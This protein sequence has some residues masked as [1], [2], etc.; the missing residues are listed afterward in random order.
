[1]VAVVT[2]GDAPRRPA[3]RELV[4][5]ALTRDAKGAWCRRFGLERS[6][7][8]ALIGAGG[9]ELWRGE[10]LRLEELRKVLAGLELDGALPP[11]HVDVQLGVAQGLIAPPFHFQCTPPVLTAGVSILT[12][13]LRGQELELCFWTTWSQASL[14]ELRR[15]AAAQEQRSAGPRTI[16]VNDGEQP[17]L[18]VRFLKRHGLAFEHAASD[19][20]RRIAR[21]Y[22][23]S[24]WPTVVRVDA[25]GRVAGA[26]FG[27]EH[28]H[29]PGPAQ[30]S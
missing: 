2:P 24:C 11:R 4:G 8:S 27:L 5:I 29:A 6:G 7:A 22:G 28:A 3:A 26:R 13:K 20:E 10:A 12:G 15:R 23:I 19:P 14:E 18:A 21:G 1:M 17:E 16:L 30:Q 25:E 9:V